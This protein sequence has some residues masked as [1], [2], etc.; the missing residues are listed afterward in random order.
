MN[1]GIVA[2]VVLASIRDVLIT[3]MSH[4]FDRLFCKV[5][6]VQSGLLHTG[7]GTTRARLPLNRSARFLSPAR[8]ANGMGL[9]SH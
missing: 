8:G 5:A 6:I 3:D 2:C 4:I 9:T 7:P 1:F